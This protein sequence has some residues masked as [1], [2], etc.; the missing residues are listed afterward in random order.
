VQKHLAV[1]KHPRLLFCDGSLDAVLGVVR[2]EDV[3]TLLLSHQQVDLRGMLKPPMFVPATLSVFK[4]VESFRA[5]KMHVALV[6]DEFGAV[7][8]IVTPSDVLQGL[9][10]E[11]QSDTHAGEILHHGARRWQWLV[12]HHAD[13]EV[14]QVVGWRP[15]RRRGG[16]LPD[17]GRLRHDAAGTRA[18]GRRDVRQRRPPVRGHRHGWAPDRQ[19]TDFADGRHRRANCPGWPRG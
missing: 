3:L 13:E 19:G 18:A 5:S 15:H 16:E 10:G 12:M 2:S 14:A 8:G 9:V 4:L 17:A 11:M 1:A 6:L 7:E